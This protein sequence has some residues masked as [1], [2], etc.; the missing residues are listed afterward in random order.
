MSG[1]LC[2][3]DHWPSEKSQ[4]VRPTAPPYLLAPQ[5]GARR[6]AG[7]G[8]FGIGSGREAVAAWLGAHLVDP[9]VV[10]EPDNW[11]SWVIPLVLNASS[12][13]GGCRHEAGAWRRRRSEGT[14]GAVSGAIARVAVTACMA[15]SGRLPLS[16]TIPADVVH[17]ARAPVLVESDALIYE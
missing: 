10:G 8:F 7:W 2:W 5:G 11:R 1:R 14:H 17:A 4:R 3:E 16:K 13:R 15:R 6:L 9:L 12:M